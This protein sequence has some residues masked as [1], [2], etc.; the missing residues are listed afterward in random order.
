MTSI[1]GKVDPVV[2]RITAADIAEALV[3]GL[4]DFQ[5]APLFGLLFGAL[6]AGGGILI[7]LCLTAFSM[8][9]LAYP[10]AA[11]FALIGPFVAIGLYEVS[12]QRE[13]GARPTLRGVCWAV[14]SRSEIGWMA[15]V[16]LFVFVIWMYQVRLLIALLIGLNASFSSLKE[17]ITVV[18]TTHEGL[19]FLAVGNAVGAALSLILFS[20]T[21]VSFPLLLD[22]DVDFVTAMITS[23]R[24]VV[25]SPGPMIGWAAIVVVL[26]MV[27]A[28]PYFLGLLVTLPVLGHA[29]WHLYR[30]LVAPPPA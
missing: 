5:A 17:F 3:E 28:I 12:R 25:T 1:S 30:R 9:Y 26:L 27:S 13:A 4:R 6:Y 24:A 15:F 14:I 10:L 8:V 16:T 23:V 11:G 7:L 2:R 22:R 19:T 18:L 21:V 29:T 20:L